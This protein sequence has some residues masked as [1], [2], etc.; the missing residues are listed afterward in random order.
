MSLMPSN[1]EHPRARELERISQILDSIPT[2]ADMVLQDLTHGVKNRNC[3]AEGMSAEHVLRAA[4]IK[5]TEGFSYNEQ[6][7]F[8]LLIQPPTA[9]SVVL[10]WFIFGMDYDIHDGTCVRDYIYVTDLAAAHVLA[11]DYLKQGGTLDVLNLSNG[12]SFS[13]KEVI[14]I[15]VKV[16]NSS[17]KTVNFARRSGDPAAVI[18]SLEKA[19]KILGWEPTY[20]ELESIIRTAWEWNKAPI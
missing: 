5:Q 12:E 18:G 1:I 13:V 20:N 14:D 15:A 16:T 8:I 10:A 2:I 9:T 11:L 7:T 17:I 6:L 19:T 3:G 4:I